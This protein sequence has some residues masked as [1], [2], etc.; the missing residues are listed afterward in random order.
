M[1]PEKIK[2]MIE[3]ITG[4]LDRYDTFEAKDEYLQTTSFGS[5]KTI[6]DVFEKSPEVKSAIQ[7]YMVNSAISQYGNPDVPG[8]EFGWSENPNEAVSNDEL[9]RRA[10]KLAEI[11]A[12]LEARFPGEELSKIQASYK[13]K[14]KRYTSL[15]GEINDLVNA[16]Q[17]KRNE[18]DKDA[19]STL[20]YKGS[21]DHRFPALIPLMS[22][23]SGLAKGA[24]QTVVGWT[25][26][27]RNAGMEKIENRAMNY[28][29]ELGVSGS[30]YIASNIKPLQNILEG[31]YDERNNKLPV[32]YAD[33]TEEYEDWHSLV[34]SANIHKEFIEKTGL[35]EA[36]K[37]A[38]LDELIEM[39]K[40]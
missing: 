39:L 15:T 34:T 12:E 35:D 5:G 20:G 36:L 37:Y 11:S 16:I 6:N 18:F 3:Y 1:D 25:D 26:L 23:M 8:F 28:N 38:P 21:F 2:R 4:T 33:L 7:E 30:D 14:Q 19:Y 29:P 17:I 31:L 27:F 24:M 13:E 40:K 10:T 22:S 9:L 32:E